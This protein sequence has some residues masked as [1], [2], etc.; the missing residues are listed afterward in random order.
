MFLSNENKAMVWQLLSENGA[1]NNIQNNSFNEVRELYEKIL[2]QISNMQNINLTE[3]NKLT[4]TEM[5]KQLSKYKNYN[6]IKSFQEIKRPL[7]EVKIQ[8]D[9]DYKD[10]QEEFIKLVKKPT[11]NEIDF[12]DKNDIPLNNNDM[13]S[14]LNNMMKMR[15]QELNQ[16]LPE[17]LNKPEKIEKIND[18]IVNQWNNNTVIS[19]EKK[20]SFNLDNNLNQLDK[21]LENQIVIL[22]ELQQ[23]KKHLNIESSNFQ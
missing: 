7:E 16:I 8:I 9:K 4:I 2:T 13:E 21:I 20:V 3:K 6:N 23:I 18:N 12:Y 14:K 17:N 5:M 15:Q 22:Q 19:E 1:F 10:K 11:Q